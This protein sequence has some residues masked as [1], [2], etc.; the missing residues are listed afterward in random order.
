MIERKQRSFTDAFRLALDNCE[1]SLQ[2]IVAAWE[3][4]TPQHRANLARA[5]GAY[6]TTTMVDFGK[7]FIKIKE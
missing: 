6:K 4:M 7:R 1:Q 5:L 3:E 2:W